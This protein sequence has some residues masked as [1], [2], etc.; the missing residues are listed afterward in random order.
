[1]FSRFFRY[2]P[3]PEEFFLHYPSITQNSIINNFNNL[4]DYLEKFEL[5]LDKLNQEGTCGGLTY[6]YA[7]YAKSDRRVDFIKCLQ[8]VSL[9]NKSNNMDLF[10]KALD[11]ILTK[12]PDFWKKH[13]IEIKLQANSPAISFKTVCNFLQDVSR[14]QAN[15]SIL[16]IN[17]NWDK[18]Y[19][20]IC[21][22]EKLTQF[23][24]KRNIQVG[25]IAL[26]SFSG[27]IFYIEKTKE[28]FYLFEPNEIDSATLFPILKNEQELAKKIYENCADYLYQEDNL[29]FSL[30]FIT[31]GNK[32]RQLDDI[33]LELKQGQN[34]TPYPTI[35]SLI[36]QYYLRKLSRFEMALA[37]FH[38]IN[39]L[40]LKTNPINPLLT[41]IEKK[42]QAYIKPEL[43]FQSD[44]ISDSQGYLNETAFEFH[45]SWLLLATEANQISLVKQLIKR[46][47]DPN[48][49]KND[50]TTPLYMAAQDGHIEIVQLLLQHGANP[51]L[52]TKDNGTTPLF[53]AA[54]KGHK[55]IVQ[56]LLQHGANPDLVTK[57]N[58]ITPLFM[59]AQK[60]HKEIVQF[61]LQHGANPDLATTD[62]G[63]TP[64]F[65]AAQKGHKEIVQFLLQHGAN[66]DL[67]TTDDRA[68]P[69]YMAAQNGHKETVQLL[70]QH[71]ANPNL[72]TKD[73]G[74]TPLFIAAQNGHTET[75]QRL[76]QHSAN[77]D[78]ARNDNGATPLFMAAQNGHKETVQLLLQHG[79]NPNLAR[80]DNGATPL[81][82]AA[83]MGHQETAQLL[84]QHGANPDLARN[85]GA[86]PL[87][88]ATQNGHKDMAQLLLQH[89]AKVDMPIKASTNILLG[90]AE[91]CGRKSILEA[92]LKNSGPLS[93]L[94]MPTSLEGFT[95]LHAAAF[96]GHNDIVKLLLK[97]GA[98]L[99]DSAAGMTALQ[100][101]QVMDHQEIVELL[102]SHALSHD[103]KFNL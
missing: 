61:L 4:V 18:T 102:E 16:Q 90:K 23:L 49:A 22:K 10:K 12:G 32:N 42:L 14:S 39:Q 77:P 50:G 30:D 65:I 7:L 100:F 13:D 37:L 53:M 33:L 71:H 54:Q 74:V 25:E 80:N 62:N 6:C 46:G 60:G 34:E 63:T 59:A 76:L 15:Q 41:Q 101:A 70:L 64:L 79:A 48:L 92:L 17:A 57:D 28:G 103:I 43:M 55:E 89:G 51:N 24:K 2:I 44:L 66:P 75:V 27:H 88:I 52:A 45:I 20:F 73:N 84:L 81:S 69:L 68:T 97:H 96:F 83:Q 31:F 47:V 99:N 8:F 36:Q 38:E 40:Q 56:L 29:A 9:L 78:L 72:A 86:T 94:S 1:M 5:N 85:N 3:P 91:K 58:G 26:V 82:M 98:D 67:A 21:P 11:N 35:N 93:D 87:F 19:S 95:V